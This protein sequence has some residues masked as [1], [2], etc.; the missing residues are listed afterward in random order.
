MRKTWATASTSCGTDDKPR[1][2]SSSLEYC[3]GAKEEDPR[4]NRM[5]SGSYMPKA[6][7]LV[8]IPKPGGGKRPLGIPTVE[9]R[10]AQ[11]AAVLFIEP[12]IEPCFDQDS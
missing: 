3:R 12:S 5:S 4:F 10:I 2:I 9:D 6:V 7:R 11:Q 8:E 1:A